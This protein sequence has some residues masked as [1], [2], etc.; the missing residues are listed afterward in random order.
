[1]LRHPLS[2]GY[3]QNGAHPGSLV[4]LVDTTED[5]ASW[6]LR[7]GMEHESPRRHWR[8][9]LHVVLLHRCISAMAKQSVE[10]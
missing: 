4:S 9:R 6:S 7:R 2:L 1:M 10:M 8:P 5:E 3:P